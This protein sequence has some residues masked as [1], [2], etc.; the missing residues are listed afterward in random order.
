[1]INP[2][3]SFNIYDYVEIILKRRWYIIIPF[4]IVLMAVSIYSFTAPKKYRA[5]TLI[6]VTPQKVPVDYVRP[7]VTSRIEERL[8]SIGQEILSRTRLE[9]I[10]GEF[11]LYQKEAKTMVMEEIVELMRKDIIVQIRGREGYFSISY[12]GKDPRTVTNVTNKLA[13]LFIEENL[14][15]R[16]QQ[17]Q[18]T[19]EFLAIELNATKA[20]LDEQEK[21]LTQF[22]RQFMFELPDQRNTNL[23]ILGRLQ[24]QLQTI[25]E[26]L[27]SAQDRKLTIQKQLSEMKN[28][29]SITVEPESPPSSSP[30][31]LPT[32]P[33]LK[34]ER[35]DQL[36]L[37]K[38]KGYLMELET[39]YKDKHPDVLATK[40][41]IGELEKKIEASKAER[42]GG[43]EIES[44][45]ILETSNLE[46]TKEKKKEPIFGMD[47]LYKELEGQLVVTDLEI[48]RLK[49]EEARTKA[50]IGEYQAR[51]ENTPIREMAMTNLIRDY[52]NIKERYQT[53]LK[54]SEEAQQAENLERRQKGEQFKVIDPA[55]IPEKPFSPNI[56]R[57]LLI[58]FLLGMGIGF[59]VAFFR[60]QIDRSFKDAEDLE[61]TL[62]FKVLANIPKIEK[63]AA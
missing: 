43:K 42:E 61:T 37:E 18:G 25:G 56:P 22:K 63:K 38:L 24:Q 15:L 54:K 11:N 47:P 5:S 32:L 48:K 28:M 16:E 44:S 51:I 45:P 9:Q 59:G 40:R 1:M 13:S 41:R 39:K 58:G 50:K 57:N 2:G 46:A 4:V 14:K 8:Q 53:L 55:R 3:K 33:Q 30:P 62:G 6:L 21:L 31:S 34:G 7:T 29:A 23:N 19:S 10:I 60:E 26:T 35:S 27:R 49:E 20:K 36:H 52:E 12:T 17:A